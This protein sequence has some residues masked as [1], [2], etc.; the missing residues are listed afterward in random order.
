MFNSTF[1]KFTGAALVSLLVACG[2]EETGVSAHKKQLKEMNYQYTPSYFVKAA[3]K[4]DVKAVELFIKAQ[5]GID[6]PNSQG[7]SALV[8]AT[9]KGHVEVVKAL[10]AG[11]ADPYLKSSAGTSSFVDAVRLNREPIVKLFV[12]HLKATPQGLSGAKFAGLAAAKQGFTPIMAM[13]V[14]GGLDV[15]T[16]DNFGY[17]LLVTAVKSGHKNTVEYLLE[18]GADV[19][20]PDKEGNTPLKWANHS[21]Y[22]KVAKVLKRHGGKQ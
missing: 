7:N 20:Q 6:D 11:G 4:G 1:K 15:N 8:M 16:T 21:G 13:L 12:D 14:D 2:G 5:I 9:N 17:S 18:K 19:N 3:S 10:L 22:P